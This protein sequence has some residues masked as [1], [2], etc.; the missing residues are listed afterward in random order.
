M[1]DDQEILLAS[2]QAQAVRRQVVVPLERGAG[3]WLVLQ[4][5]T[6]T[7]LGQDAK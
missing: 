3:H 5:S 6:L 1:A 4:L 7:L 2:D